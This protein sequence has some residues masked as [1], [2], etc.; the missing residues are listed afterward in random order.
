V[1]APLEEDLR[2]VLYGWDQAGQLVRVQP[3][4]TA[5]YWYPTGLWAPGQRLRVAFPPLPL[6]EKEQM[7]V[8]VLR[9]GAALEEV[10]GRL[11]PITPAAGRT[12][13]LREQGTIVELERP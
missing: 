1:L 11:G 2:L 3:A 6:G 12:L 7:G 9:A 10:A 13:S 5:M 8:A 4:E